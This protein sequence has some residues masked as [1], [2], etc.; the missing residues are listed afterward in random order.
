[1]NIQEAKDTL[2]KVINKSRIHMYKPIQNRKRF[3]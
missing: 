1:M 3:N 2:D